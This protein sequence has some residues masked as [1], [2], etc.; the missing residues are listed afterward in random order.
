ML[1]MRHGRSL[2]PA[3][4][5]VETGVKTEREKREA[6]RAATVSA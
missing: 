5:A 2:T 3:R 1:P 4:L 6:W